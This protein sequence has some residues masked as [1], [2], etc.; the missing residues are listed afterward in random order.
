MATDA[1]LEAIVLA[2]GLGSRFGGGKLSHAYKNGMLIDFALDAAI[3]APVR[4]VTVVVGA[5]PVIEGLATLRGCAVV[6]A[7]DYAQ[8]LSASL[9]AGIAALPEDADGAFIFLGDMPRIPH[10]VLADLAQALTDHDAAAPV[11]DGQRGHPVLVSRRLFPQLMA[12]EGDHGAGRVLAALGERLALVDAS[13]DGV[14]F[15][16]DER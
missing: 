13:D 1:R 16:V 11:F 3:A 2:A 10:G 15:D 5:D 4:G 14:L 12:L 7:A 9:K 6:E 8:G